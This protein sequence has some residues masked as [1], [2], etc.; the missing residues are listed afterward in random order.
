MLVVDYEF[1]SIEMIPS[2]KEV[3]Y[4]AVR[5]EFKEIFISEAQ[6]KKTYDEVLYQVALSTI[7]RL[8]ATDDVNG[9]ASVIFNGWVQS[10]DRASGVETHP[11]IMSV[12]A[13]KD[14]FLALNLRQVDP[15]LCF[16]KLK[17]IS[18]SKLTELN[19][20]K[21]IHCLTRT[22]LDSSLLTTLLERLTNERILPPWIGW[23]SRT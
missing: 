9:L 12:Q 4:V 6:L 16:K 17:G 15:R 23:T 10:I 3:K 18:G 13:S 7:H 2:L 19:P 20:V 11:C 22:I 14:E 5:S 8:F 21:P 1:P